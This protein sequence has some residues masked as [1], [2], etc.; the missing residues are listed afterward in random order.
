MPDDARQLGIRAL[1]HHLS[2][3]PSHDA[4]QEGLVDEDSAIQPLF[5]A[6]IVA[7]TN[8]GQSLTLDDRWSSARSG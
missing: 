3:G 8:G 2:Q 6:A 7:T 1:R 5:K 4:S